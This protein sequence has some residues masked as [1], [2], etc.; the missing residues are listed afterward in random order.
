MAVLQ[1]NG[2][3][4]HIRLILVIRNL[5][6]LPTHEGIWQ[7]KEDETHQENQT[8]PKII[9]KDQNGDETRRQKALHSHHNHSRSYIRQPFQRISRNTGNLAQ[10]ILIKVTHGQIAHVLGN[11]NPLLSTGMITCFCLQHGDF[12]GNPDV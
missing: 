6:N 12:Q 9:E 4:V 1:N 5:A 7:E 8:N 10:A 3:Q 2:Y 11:F